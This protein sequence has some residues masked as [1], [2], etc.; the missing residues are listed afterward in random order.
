M[1]L[2]VFFFLPS[3]VSTSLTG[4]PA[5]DALTEKYINLSMEFIVAMKSTDVPEQELHQLAQRVLTYENDVHRVHEIYDNF[6]SNKSEEVKQVFIKNYLHDKKL[7]YVTERLNKLLGYY[8]TKDQ[9]Q[10]IRNTL[11]EQY[12]SGVDKEQM[13]VAL[14]KE[15]E[16]DMSEKKSEKTINM[17]LKDLKLLN[18]RQ[19][20]TMRLILCLAL[21]FAVN[22]EDTNNDETKALKRH[23][24]HHRAKRQ[25][26]SSSSN[27]CC[28]AATTQTSAQCIPACIIQCCQSSNNCQT[29]SSQSSCTN[30][31]QQQCGQT[32]NSCNQC[33][34]NCGSSCQTQS[35][36]QSCI[37]LNC[38]QACGSSSNN[39]NNN[40]C[41][42][43]TPQAPIIIVIPAQSTTSSSCNSNCGQCQSSCQTSCNNACST[44]QC[45]QT[46]TNQCQQQCNCCTTTAAPNNCQSTCQST[47]QQTQSLSCVPVCLNICEGQSG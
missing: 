24:F 28:S 22:A 41:Q 46:C 7:E 37:Q 35:C 47:C 45:A 18:K 5:S 14:R 38:Q 4:H 1:L 19:A 29:S 20:G 34:S 3:F 10:R 11:H 15:L 6:L 44:N 8:L 13:V 9:I 32:S 27:S 40:N 21:F 25:C 42:V 31:C 36:Q 12:D 39:C 2:T 43:T 16:K 17:L 30:Q 33:Q 26:C 23:Q